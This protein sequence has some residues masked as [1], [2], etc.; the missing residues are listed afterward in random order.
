MD[1]TYG[2]LAWEAYVRAVGGKTFDGLHLPSW[3][4]LG[5][6]QQLGWETAAKAVRDA[7]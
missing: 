2:Q 5:E 3:D 4:N 6:R 7:R 1:F